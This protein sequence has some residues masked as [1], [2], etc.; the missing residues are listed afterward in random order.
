MLRIGVPVGVKKWVPMVGDYAEKEAI[1][2][3]VK[4][5]MEGK[6]AEDMRSRAKKL[7]SMAKQ[8][9]EEGGSSSLDL[10]ALIQQLSSR[11]H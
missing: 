7:A 2:T 1:E 10:D 3:A 9:M 8:A 5:I 11:G 6:E 4:E